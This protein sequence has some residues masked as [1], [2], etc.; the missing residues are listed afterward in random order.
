MC[1]SFLFTNG[2]PHLLGLRPHVWSLRGMSELSLGALILCYCCGVVVM[3]CNFL[4]LFWINLKLRAFPSEEGPLDSFGWPSAHH[5]HVTWPKIVLRRNKSGHAVLASLL[6]TGPRLWKIMLPKNI[7]SLH[8]GELCN[9]TFSDIVTLGSI[10]R[11]VH[12]LLWGNKLISQRIL[13]FLL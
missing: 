11:H 1:K 2:S 10:K 5:M 6:M 13:S 4:L 8:V 3:P 9:G 12:R 7:C